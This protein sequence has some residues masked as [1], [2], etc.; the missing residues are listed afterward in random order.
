MI[1]WFLFIIPRFAELFADMGNE[2]PFITKAVIK[3]S[4][5][6]INNATLLSSVLISV[7]IYIYV[8][9]KT[10]NGEILNKIPLIR[11]I[12]RDIAVMNFFTEMSLLLKEKVNLIDSLE[13]LENSNVFKYVTKIKEFIK[14][15]NTLA[16]S[17]KKCKI[18]QI[19][20]ISIIESG[21]KSGDFWPSFK[22]SSDILRLKINEI[23]EKIINM[24]QP[25]TLIFAGGLLILIVYSVIIPMYFN[26]DIDF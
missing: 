23:S 9:F 11:N 3:V 18:F 7:A 5:F 6:C 24:I 19:H 21:E 1:F 25:I 15:G 20:E 8:L 16:N 2:L 13:C 14:C 22:S 12:K 10:T 4:H 26:L 17:M